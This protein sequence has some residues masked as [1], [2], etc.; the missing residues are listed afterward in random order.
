M[1]L[2]ARVD[3]AELYEEPTVLMIAMRRTLFISAARVPIV[4]AAGSRRRG[5]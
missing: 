3:R 4:H 5:A 2:L 1:G